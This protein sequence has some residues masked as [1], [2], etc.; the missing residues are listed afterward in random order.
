MIDEY[1]TLNNSIKFL[2][3]EADA[4]VII[5]DKP[6]YDPKGKSRKAMPYKPAIYIE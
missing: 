2:A 6:T 4:D 1:S 5:Y 3:G